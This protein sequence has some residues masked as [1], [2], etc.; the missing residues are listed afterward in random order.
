MFSLRELCQN[1][2]NIAGLLKVPIHPS[3]PHQLLSDKR[4][5]R[6]FRCGKAYPGTD[7][8]VISCYLCQGIGDANVFS[9]SVCLPLIPECHFTVSFL[10]PDT[11]EQSWQWAIDFT[12]LFT[13]C[14]YILNLWKN[15]F[16]FF[17]TERH[18]RNGH[19]I[20]LD[21]CFKSRES[22]LFFHLFC[23]PSQ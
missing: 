4:R 1:R 11:N 18:D 14:E 20:R 13:I 12:K 5:C 19:I 10:R 8:T 2:P 22:P 9:M 16:D 23:L 15:P 7:N 6:S 17:E 21:A 3:L